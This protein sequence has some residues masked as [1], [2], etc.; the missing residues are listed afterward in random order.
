MLGA[1]PSTSQ[2]N[3]AGETRLG[4]GPKS[5]VRA[6]GFPAGVPRAQ[7]SSGRHQEPEP[8]RAQPS[9]SA[10]DALSGA[11]TA[12]HEAVRFSPAPSP[13]RQRLPAGSHALLPEHPLARVS[14]W[15][16]VSEPTPRPPAVL[17]S[18]ER[19]PRGG[20]PV[21]HSLLSPG[22]PQEGAGRA[23]QEVAQGAGPHPRGPELRPRQHTCRSDVCSLLFSLS[24]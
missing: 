6:Q 4:W 11:E 12:A 22:K 16:P 21:A 7:L 19:R 23:V 24:E 18:A 2:P 10:S 5:Q 20:A 1:R 9:L 3:R 13:A 14:C 15:G 8:N 17:G